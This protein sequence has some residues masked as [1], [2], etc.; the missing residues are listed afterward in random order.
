[1]GTAETIVHMH[2]DANAAVDGLSHV[3]LRCSRSAVG[4]KVTN[5]AKLRESQE[6]EDAGSLGVAARIKLL[7]ACGLEVQMH[8]RAPQTPSTHEKERP[9]ANKLVNGAKILVLGRLLFKSFSGAAL[10]CEAKSAVTAAWKTLESQRRKLFRT[11]KLVLS[12]SDEN[13]SRAE[14]LKSLCAYSLAISA[15]AR[16]VADYFLSVRGEAMALC[17]ETS[18]RE[19]GKC[20]I[21]DIERCLR[22]Y[23]RTMLDFQRLVPRKLADALERLAQIP[24]VDDSGV[25][26]VEG[27]RLEV[28]EKWCSD[29]IRYFTPYIRHDDL[30]G[31]QAREILAQWVR[32]GLQVVLGGLSKTLEQM[33][34][35]RVVAQLR[36][37]ILQLWIYEGGKARGFDPGRMLNS[38]R[39]VINTQL[40]SILERKVNELQLVSSQISATLESWTEGVTDKTDSLWE[41]NTMDMDMVGG[42]SS[43]IQQVLSRE[44][45]RNAAVSNT[46]DRYSSWH[47]V[48]DEVAEVTS[49][50]RKT[51]WESSLEEIED[52]ETIETQVRMLNKE[53]VE[54]ME[55]KLNDGV[56]SAFKDLEKAIADQWKAKADSLNAGHMAIYFL[57]II[58]DMRCQL[59]PR[60]ESIDNFCLALVPELHRVLAETVAASPIDELAANGLS[61]PAAIGRGLWEGEPAL[62]TWPSP[63]TFMFLRN[64]SHAM[65]E[66]G[67]DLWTVASLRQLKN[68]LNFQLAQVWLEALSTFLQRSREQQQQIDEGG[69]DNDKGKPTVGDEEEE[70]EEEDC[71]DEKNDH[72]DSKSSAFGTQTQRRELFTQWLFDISLIQ[73]F[74]ASPSAGPSSDSSPLEGLSKAEHAI[75]EATGLDSNDLKQR[76]MDAA[77]EYW[78]RTRLLFGLIQ[79]PPPPLPSPS[80]SSLPALRHT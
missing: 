1:M 3:G 74:T 58:R 10:T 30:A 80:P 26:S 25:R 32:I 57:R 34:E 77:H 60:L 50:L 18:E 31:E 55:E 68:H 62:P 75:Y 48:I 7:E 6:Q 17:F 52:E 44:Y 69:G 43:L 66:A 71:E 29:E 47:R 76:V 11:V 39:Q 56:A 51:R 36:G 42:A 23:T 28:Y 27:L 67:I 13:L 59:P 19:G 40:L 79:G 8:L 64:L 41:T 21:G 61:K 54:L 78:K 72:D 65:E 22:L 49:R 35:F 70:E 4:S 38:F 2:D 9:S 16:D 63:W 73:R 53:D 46:L 24:I 14:I 12:D 33:L 37:S 20:T 45:G 5:L 15:G